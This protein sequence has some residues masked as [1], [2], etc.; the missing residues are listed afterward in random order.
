[1]QAGGV[2]PLP[3]PLHLQH[4][5]QPFQGGEQ[6]LRTRRE[7]QL[8]PQGLPGQGL[9]GE[10]VHRPAGDHVALHEDRHPVADLLHL[11]QKV[12]GEHHRHTLGGELP[13]ELQELPGA[14]GVEAERRLV[15]D[16]Q[17]GLLQQHVGHAEPLPHAPG[18][19]PHPGVGGLAESHPPEQ[20]VDLGRRLPPGDAVELRRVEQVLPAGHLVVEAHVVGQVAG[21]PLD[22]DGIP[23]RVVA[24]HPDPAFGGLGQAQE[25]QDGGRLAG[26]VGAEQPEDLTGPHLQVQAVH[27]GEVPVA[28]HQAAGF[29]D[30]LRHRPH[31]RPKVRKTQ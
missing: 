10:F 18:V 7:L 13:D 15:H 26:P 6:R 9:L 19:G 5:L 21:Q 22:G 30:G 24:Q 2:A 16:D 31:L 12:R 11:V 28:L 25:H 8:Q 17:P 3:G 14:L 4:A 1:M 29:D 20:P 23:H 27:R